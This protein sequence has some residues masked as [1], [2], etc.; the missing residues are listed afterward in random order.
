MSVA[1]CSYEL[2]ELR[3]LHVAGSSMKTH[4]SYVIQISKAAATKFDVR[5][6]MVQ[7][8]GARGVVRLNLGP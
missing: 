7:A 8:L 6:W 5:H 1:V 4:I 2:V 3:V